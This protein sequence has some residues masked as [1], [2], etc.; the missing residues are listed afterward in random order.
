MMAT[1]TEIGRTERVK[2]TG[3]TIIVAQTDLIQT[4]YVQE[5]TEVVLDLILG[6]RHIITGTIVGEADG[7]RSEQASEMC[8]TGITM[9]SQ[10][11]SF[12]EPRVFHT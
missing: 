9:N 7:I 10:K 6:D 2:E 8:G 3:A 1:E 5:M 12:S 4:Q 11:I